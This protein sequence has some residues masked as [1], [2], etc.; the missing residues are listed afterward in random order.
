VL[1]TNVYLYGSPDEDREIAPDYRLSINSQDY[2]DLA[3]S[4]H[5]GVYRT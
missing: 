1:G 4:S 5:G 2:A 3:P